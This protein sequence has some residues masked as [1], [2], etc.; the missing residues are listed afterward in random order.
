MMIAPKPTRIVLKEMKSHGFT[1]ENGKGSHS[2]WI[3]PHGKIKVTIP[4][5]HKTISPGVL[6]SIQQTI[7]QCEM[8][9]SND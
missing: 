5:G 7:E 9:H 1:R 2:K 8:E 4:D 3:C 6:R